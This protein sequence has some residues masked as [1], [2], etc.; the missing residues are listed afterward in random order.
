MNLPS[1]ISVNSCFNAQFVLQ[2]TKKPQNRKNRDHCRVD[3]V[4]NRCDVVVF[5]RVQPKLNHCKQ[6]RRAP[7]SATSPTSKRH[8]DAVELNRSAMSVKR[9]CTQSRPRAFGTSCKQD[10]ILLNILCLLTEPTRQQRAS[11]ERFI[12]STRYPLVAHAPAYVKRWLGQALSRKYSRVLGRGSRLEIRSLGRYKRFM[13]CMPSY[14][15][16]LTWTLLRE[17]QCTF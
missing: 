15:L 4:N 7:C 6:S 3:R 2:H 11:R 9:Q 16:N 1:C 10:K 14:N 12:M 13:P 5:H 8:R 17:R